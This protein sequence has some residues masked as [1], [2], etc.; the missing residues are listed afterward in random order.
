MK[1]RLVFQWG[2]TKRRQTDL[3][4]RDMSYRYMLY[5]PETE[6]NY[7]KGDEH[8]A[9][10][11][12]SKLGISWPPRIPTR[13][14]SPRY[15]FHRFMSVLLAALVWICCASP[16]GISV[17]HLRLDGGAGTEATVAAQDGRRNI[18]T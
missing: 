15:L 6:N 9:C 12:S 3:F 5:S 8:L 17:G 4:Q 11:V 1:N 2:H 13:T 18:E 10:S 14:H 7:S 16:L